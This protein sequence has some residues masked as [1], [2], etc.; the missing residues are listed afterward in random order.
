[1]RLTSDYRLLTLFDSWI[2]QELPDSRNHSHSHA[3]IR[4]YAVGGAK[5]WTM[6]FCETK[7]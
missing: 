4:A 6:G 1:M 7:V 2:L 3:G 5:N